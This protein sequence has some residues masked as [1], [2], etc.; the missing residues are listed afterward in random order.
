MYMPF[1]AEIMWA[2]SKI[3]LLH[4]CGYDGLFLK[5]LYLHPTQLLTDLLR[6]SLVADNL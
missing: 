6:L 3:L 4:L 2:L 1:P 5:V